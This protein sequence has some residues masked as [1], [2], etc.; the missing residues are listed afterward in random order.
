MNAGCNLN[1]SST[2]SATLGSYPVQ[3]NAT[4]P[5][6]SASAPLMIQIVPGSDFALTSNTPS[7]TTAPAGQ[8]ALTLSV[9][10]AVASA[11]TVTFSISG[12]PAGVTSSFSPGSITASGSTV[13]TLSTPANIAPGS[14][15][16]TITAANGEVTKPLPITLIIDPLALPYPWTPEN[17]GVAGSTITHSNGVFTLTGPGNA[18]SGTVDAFHW[19]TQPMPGDGTL[20]ARVSRLQNPGKAGLMLRESAALSVPGVFF[21][22]TNATTLT[23]QSRAANDAAWIPQTTAVKPIPTWL[24][25]QRT[26]NSI[27]ASTSAD[28]LR[29][30]PFGTPIAL[31]LTNTAAGLVVASETG[32][33]VITADFDHAIV[34]PGFYLSDPAPLTKTTGPG[35]QQATYAFTSQPLNGFTGTITPSVS[36]LP[37]GATAQFAGEE[38]HA[39]GSQY[40]AEVAGRVYVDTAFNRAARLDEYIA[41]AG[42]LPREPAPEAKDLASGAALRAFRMKLEG[43]A[44]PEA[45]LRARYV[46]INAD[47]TVKGAWLPALPV[48]QALLAQTRR[49]AESYNPERIRVPALAIYAVPGAPAD[50]MRRWYG[51]DDPVIRQNVEALFKLERDRFRRHAEWFQAF[52]ERGRVSKISGAH[53][54]LTHPREVQRLIDD[55]VGSLP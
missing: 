41:A 5:I 48:R 36:G 45:H 53:L 38:M 13:L 11:G 32:G 19:A 33:P 3:I 14:Y 24:R 15:P 35:S 47:G 4:G 43:A 37:A 29:W 31:T 55:F 49:Y 42:K 30:T 23:L 20:I 52:A 51:A 6:L 50:L 44:L 16:L 7:A 10:P 22:W 21:G 54:F 12:L 26:A 46:V 40:A 9:T 27:T 17:A 39:L 34:A 1:I 28:G 2:V 25:L 18:L 8:T